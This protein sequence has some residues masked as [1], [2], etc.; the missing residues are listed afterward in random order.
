MLV[1]PAGRPNAQ[2]RLPSL[3][4]GLERYLA[5][6]VH[7]T[8]GERQAL[9]AGGPVTKLLPSDQTKEVAVF[10][11]IW[12]DTPAADYVDRVVDIENFEKGGGFRRTRKISDPPAL[13]DFAEIEL[14]AK[15]VKDLRRCRPGDCEIK[16][17]ASGLE[18]F[19]TQVRWGTAGEKTDAEAVFRRLMFDYVKGYREGGNARLA[20]YRDRADPVTVADELRSMVER[21][22]L[23]AR[24]PNLRDYLLEYPS[25]PLTGSTD[26]LY[27]QEAQFGLKPIIRVSHL[28]IDDRPDQ[29]VIASKMLYAS[30][31]F[32]TALEQRIL[33]PDPAR[34]PGFWLVTTNRSRSDGLKGIVGRLVRGRVRSEAQKRTEAVLKMTK[35][36]LEAGT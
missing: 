35:A 11:A 19:R 7:P 6:E 16:L 25:S 9:L 22:P 27:W 14:S 2:D 29:T 21:A 36:K 3:P 26:F 13:G 17:S 12:I 10:G 23:L 5:A 15:D 31:Y 1:A 24:M 30:H 28:V 33:Q 8:A 20:V 4:E 34:G 32:W 18:A